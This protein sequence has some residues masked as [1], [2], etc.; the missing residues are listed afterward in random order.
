MLNYM[1]DLT[2]REQRYAEQN[3][4]DYEDRYYDA[5]VKNAAEKKAKDAQ[6]AVAILKDLL[7]SPRSYTTDDHEF[8]WEIKSLAQKQ[9]VDFEMSVEIV[10]VDDEYGYTGKSEM[11]HTILIKTS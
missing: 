10:E 11:L 8:M 4:K 6:R 7:A 9:G 5:M 2:P 1:P 3:Q